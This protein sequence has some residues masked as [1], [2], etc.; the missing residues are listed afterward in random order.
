MV[1]LWYYNGIII[2]FGWEE[3]RRNIGGKA[4]LQH[5]INERNENFVYSVFSVFSRQ[6]S[7]RFFANIIFFVYF[8]IRVGVYHPSS[9]Q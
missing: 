3:Q 9:A 5:G 8:C 1:I 2:E 6:F 4:D 7:S